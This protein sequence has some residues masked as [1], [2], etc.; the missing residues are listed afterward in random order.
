MTSNE[1]T[2]DLFK[3]Q[4]S[5]LVLLNLGVLA[6][7]TLIHIFFLS[8]LGPPSRALLLTLTGR[9]FLFVVELLWLQRAELFNRSTVV[10]YQQLSVWLN[11]AFAFLV[12][13]LAGSS[14]ASGVPD[15]HYA[16][17]MIPPII[18]AAFYFRLQGALAVS[19]VATVL[20]FLQVWFFY[21]AHPPTDITEYFEA[22]T[23]GLI[24]IA[25][26][27]VTWLLVS[28]LQREQMRLKDNLAELRATRDRLVVEE[29]LAAVGRLASG[30]AHEI[31]NPVAMISSSLALA[32]RH[33]RESALR[34][35]MFGVATQEAARLETLTSD[36]LNYARSKTPKRTPVA[37][38]DSLSYVASLGSAKANEGNVEIKLEVAPD[39]SARIDEFQIQHALL[40]LL[41]NAFEAMPDGGC[42]TLGAKPEADN[43]LT[44]YVENCG[45]PI[46]DEAAAH[47]FE[48]FFTTKQRGTGLG[49]SIVHSIAQAHGGRATLAV[50]KPGQVRFCITFPDGHNRSTT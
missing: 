28:N 48:P 23:V 36:F 9:F 14:S 24:F 38:A 13:Y 34:N 26:T 15:A 33:G 39:L 30:I 6:A 42:V 20:T 27:L 41:T 1:P 45:E 44:L 17:L 16:V 7:L 18:S 5:I 10:I 31:R 22:A 43:E 25:V 35:E 19:T 47:I 4:Q 50:N 37:L 2:S 8:L 29:K 11:L 40:N 49:L 12:S 21:R 32:M 3:G 46:S